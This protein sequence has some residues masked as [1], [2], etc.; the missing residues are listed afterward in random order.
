MAG[1]VC[2]HNSIKLA[3]LLKFYCIRK[4]E[5]HDSTQVVRSLEALPLE[6]IQVVLCDP[7]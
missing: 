1:G 4:V 6:G 3:T 2:Y 7:G 5:S